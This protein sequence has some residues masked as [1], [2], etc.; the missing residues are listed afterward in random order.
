M[1]SFHV[2]SQSIADLERVLA[3]MKQRLATLAYEAFKK[4]PA[5][6]T[7]DPSETHAMNAF[8][9]R[10]EREREDARFEACLAAAK[11]PTRVV[12]VPVAVHVPVA[13]A[14]TIPAAPVTRT[15][16]PKKDF[17]VIQKAFTGAE[18]YVESL[19]DRWIGTIGLGGISCDGKTYKSPTG[20]CSAHAA[21]ITQMHPQPTEAGNG[22]K[23]V[24]MLTGQ[25]AGKSISDVYQALRQSAT[26]PDESDET[27][28]SESDDALAA[29]LQHSPV[30][31]A[32]PPQNEVIDESVPVNTL[33]APATL[34]PS[35]PFVC[36]RNIKHTPTQDD[37]DLRGG[38]LLNGIWMFNGVFPDAK[39][40]SGACC[41]VLKRKEG[42]ET[43]QWDGPRH[44][45]LQVQGTWKP[46]SAIFPKTKTPVPSPRPASMGG[47]GGSA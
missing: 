13:V 15:P 12:N 14:V 30:S 16:P 6:S 42:S 21:R 32:E 10:F 27:A 40:P 9:D 47:G 4:S 23:Y 11:P 7:Q 24:K 22:W 44:V 28:G 17:S 33:V 20:F 41:T 38:R 29:R 31:A 37:I 26:E 1:S 5:E 3:D 39:S 35:I 25:Y 43:N 34:I 19:G 36:M 18:V 45:L 46:Y 2:L 8:L